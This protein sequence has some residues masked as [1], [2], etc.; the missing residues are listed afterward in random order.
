M[1]LRKGV[2]GVRRAV[3]LELRPFSE[4]NGCKDVPAKELVSYAGGLVERLWNEYAPKAGNNRQS[5]RRFFEECFQGVA[6]G[7][8][9][10][11]T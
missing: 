10:Q 1:C 5:W 3:H 2:T 11:R 8:R 7:G 4:E 6:V 9:G